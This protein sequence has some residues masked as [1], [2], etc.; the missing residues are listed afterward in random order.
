MLQAEMT[1][2]LGYEKHATEGRNSGNSRNGTGGKTLKTEQGRISIEVPRD[3]NGDFEPQVIGKVETR[4]SGFDDK[5]I[6]MYARGMTTTEIGEHLEDLYG[7][8]VS[9][10]FISEVLSLIHI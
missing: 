7:V 6:S 2:H 5:I 9:P 1:N 4:F 10:S 3:R 8:D